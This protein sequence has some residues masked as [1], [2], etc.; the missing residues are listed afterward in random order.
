[1]DLPTYFF[2]N[3]VSLNRVI[4]N[5]I[6]TLGTNLENPN[7]EPTSWIMQSNWPPSPNIFCQKWFSPQIFLYGSILAFPGFS[8]EITKQIYKWDLSSN[9]NN[10]RCVKTA[11]LSTGTPMFTQHAGENEDSEKKS[12]KLP[13]IQSSRIY[14]ALWC[15]NAKTGL[16]K[17]KRWIEI[18]FCF[19]EWL[20]Q[21][22]LLQRLYGDLDGGRGNPT[23]GSEVH[24]VRQIQSKQSSYLISL[25]LS[26]L[27][28]ISDRC[29]WK[30]FV[31]SYCFLFHLFCWKSHKESG[32]KVILYG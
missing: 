16:R 7:S 10:L 2:L 4:V 11:L 26:V 13:F 22:H 30:Y 15:S 6:F 27:N 12:F 9:G 32:G 21:F 19:Q 17:M 5:F 20:L 3:K 1:M 29:T 28:R 24:K 25:S 8:S 18:I 23:E 31:R 14:C